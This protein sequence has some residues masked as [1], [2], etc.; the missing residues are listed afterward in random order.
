M[1]SELSCTAPLFVQLV[2]ERMV[3]EHSCST[4]PFRSP[5]CAFHIVQR[6]T[7][8]CVSLIS[9][10]HTDL[11]LLLCDKMFDTVDQHIAHYSEHQDRFA[12]VL[13]PDVGDQSGSLDRTALSTGCEP[14]LFLPQSSPHFI[15]DEELMSVENSQLGQAPSSPVLECDV[16]QTARGD[17][18]AVQ[19]AAQRRRVHG[20]VPVPPQDFFNQRAATASRNCSCYCNELYSSAYDFLIPRR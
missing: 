12:R 17:P 18:G 7:H 15:E 16:L 19:R 20:E 5:W 1:F 11:D 10:S 6:Y 8:F 4:V 3:I 9:D 2:F 14:N 13:H